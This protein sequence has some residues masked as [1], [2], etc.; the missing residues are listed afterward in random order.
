MD[1]GHLARKLEY[2][3]TNHPSFLFGVNAVS[4]H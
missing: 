3:Y 1:I 4:E 2:V